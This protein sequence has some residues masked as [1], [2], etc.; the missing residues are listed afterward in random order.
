M[1]YIF[2]LMQFYVV[3]VKKRIGWTDEKTFIFQWN[4]YLMYFCWV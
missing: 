4:A 3:L 1:K 2:S